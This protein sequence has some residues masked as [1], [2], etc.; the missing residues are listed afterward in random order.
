[1]RT[2]DCIMRSFI[3]V[4]R[5]QTKNGVGGHVARVGE[6]TIQ[7]GEETLGKNTTKKN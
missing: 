7:F 4:C 6:R 2:V 3:F 1:M 5:D